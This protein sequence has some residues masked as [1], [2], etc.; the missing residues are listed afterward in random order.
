MKQ[1]YIDKIT[2]ACIK[3]N[4]GI[5]IE[6]TDDEKSGKFAIQAYSYR[7]IQLADVLLAIEFRNGK[8]RGTKDFNMWVF[9]KEFI[10][11]DKEEFT[12]EDK[13]G[14]QC[15]W[16][17]TKPLEEQEVETLKFIAEII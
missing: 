10:F 17:L 15:G 6:N 1:Q 8:T 12:F 11:E 16:D 7:P 2:K 14:F 13:D 3:A 5:V 4:P 9:Q